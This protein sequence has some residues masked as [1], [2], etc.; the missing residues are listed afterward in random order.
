MNLDDFRQIKSHLTFVELNIKQCLIPPNKPIQHVHFVQSGIVSVVAQASNNRRIEVGLCGRDGLSGLPLILGVAHGNNEEMVQVPGVAL[1]M[2]ATEFA[3]ALAALPTFRAVLLCYVHTFMIQMSQSM[4]SIGI[5]RLE[6][7]LA[8]WLLMCQDRLYSPILPLTHEFLAT[9]LS[10][11]RAGVT[12]SIHE[13]EGHR[14]IK[15]NRGQIIVL[16]RAG[17]QKLAGPTYGVSEQ[18]HDRLL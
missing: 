3:R 2:P 10:V 1:R 15:A 8:R 17:L 13:L 12:T 9:M 6:Q 14:L 18:E 7:R 11:R 4:L 16:D 5:D